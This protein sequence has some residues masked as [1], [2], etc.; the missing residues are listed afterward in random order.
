ELYAGG[1]GGTHLR[2][3]DLL[4]KVKT[5][6]EVLE[7]AG[8]YIQFYRETAHYLER[9]SKWLERMKLET[10]RAVVVEDQAAR[11]QLNE[12]LDEALSVAKEPWK[13]V[14]ESPALRKELY[15]HVSI[16]VLSK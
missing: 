12:R 13:E 4:C 3:A 10:I 14:V 15:E 2:A 1:N 8:A 11:A 6:E 5:S 7:I 16:P 9:T